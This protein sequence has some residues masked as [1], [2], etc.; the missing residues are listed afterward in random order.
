MKN[1]FEKMMIGSYVLIPFGLLLTAITADGR[2]F[3]I[4]FG[5]FALYYIAFLALSSNEYSK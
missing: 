5:V 1:F 2:Y 4:S 3:T